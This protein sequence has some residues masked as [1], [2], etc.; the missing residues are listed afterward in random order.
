MAFWQ[1]VRAW[2]AK[3]DVGHLIK[4]LEHIDP[5]SR[6]IAASAL[7]KLADPRAVEPLITLLRRETEPQVRDAAV[8]SAT[9]LARSSAVSSETRD[10]IAAALNE[11]N[12]PAATAPPPASAKT[13]TDLPP[14]RPHDLAFAN[15]LCHDC[16]APLYECRNCRGGFHESAVCNTFSSPGG[17]CREG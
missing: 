13:P 16:G 1:R 14:W 9:A 8:V 3:G 12:P 2:E 17:R 10:R 4:A 11:L 7:G 15:E 6:R 5:A